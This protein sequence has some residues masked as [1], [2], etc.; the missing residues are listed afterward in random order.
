MSAPAVSVVVGSYNRRR[1]LRATIASVRDELTDLAHEIIVVDGG[2]D[3]G[4]LR[5]LVRQKDVISVIQ[6]NRGEW[7]GR[8]I[9]R[10]SWGYFMNLGFRIAQ[11][12]AICMLS[13]DCLVVP[14]AIRNGLRTLS[15][16]SADGRVGAVAFWWRDWPNDDAYRVGR[17]F[18][19]RLFVN[20]G[21][22][23]REALASVGFADEEAFSF[24][25]GDGDLALRLADTGWSC[26]IGEDSF[27]EH[28]A[29]ANLAV[30]A[31]N[32]R[33][34]QADWDA[35]R[36][37]WAH[38]GEPQR[39]WESRRFDDPADT[40]HRYWGPAT[41]SPVLRRLGQMAFHARRALSE[42]RAG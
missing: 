18:G 7:R 5:W 23:A 37:R 41:T 16:P 6:H 14:G 38:L 11:A 22:Y 12:P 24:Y 31:S 27:V 28:L 13:D 2:S 39:D 10:R 15:E 42:R 9:R 30:R 29:H 20:H 8:P 35:Y 26:V 32:L 34:Q 4:T 3:D 21:L 1:Y 36:A 33:T 25:H 19:D 17:A 40:V